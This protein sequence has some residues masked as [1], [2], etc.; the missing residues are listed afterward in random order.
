MPNRSPDLRG[1]C[2]LIPLGPERADR[3]LLFGR[4]QVCF[5]SVG[6]MTIFVQEGWFPQL[7]YGVAGGVV[8]R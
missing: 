3:A 2:A 8:S 4:S 7:P 5:C 1:R 6:R